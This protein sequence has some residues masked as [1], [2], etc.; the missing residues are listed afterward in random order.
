MS[1]NNGLML[2]KS[3]QY[4]TA[5]SD[6]TVECKFHGKGLCEIKSPYKTR[7][8]SPAA[9]HLAYLKTVNCNPQLKRNSDYYF[10]VQAQM[11]VTGLKYCDFFVY[12][13]HG[14]HLEWIDYDPELWKAIRSHCF[15][16]WRDFVVPAV[17]QSQSGSTAAVVTPAMSTTADL[18][19][20]ITHAMSTTT[21]LTMS[22]DPTW[23]ET[24]S[25]KT[26]LD[27]VFTFA[28]KLLVLHLGDDASDLFLD[29]EEVSICNALCAL[30]T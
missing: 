18:A 10:Q 17:E 9:S 14:F 19:A 26:Y 30:P 20:S 2:S 8:L 11:G 21:D 23:S 1:A 16:S 7:H 13:M 3:D 6:L 22:T 28:L 25:S 5:S 15:N 24:V 12:T 4:I 29:S 27:T